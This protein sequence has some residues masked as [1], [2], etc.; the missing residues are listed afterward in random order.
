MLENIIH[1]YIVTTDKHMNPTSENPDAN[2]IERS[3][4]ARSELYKLIIMLRKD[5]AQF[6]DPESQAVFSMAA[7]V[8]AGLARAFRIFEKERKHEGFQNEEADKDRDD[9]DCA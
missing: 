2:S 3:L 5:A 1:Y 4:H 7:E 9:G 8:A 6:D